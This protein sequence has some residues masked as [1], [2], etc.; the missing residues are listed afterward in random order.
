MLNFGGERVSSENIWGFQR[1][2][3]PNP[4]EF[5]VAESQLEDSKDL[6]DRP[7]LQQRQ[8]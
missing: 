3:D 7:L 2:S 4:H 1:S 5:Q 6:H 8:W